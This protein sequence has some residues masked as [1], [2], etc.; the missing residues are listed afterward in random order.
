MSIDEAGIAYTIGCLKNMKRAG[1]AKNYREALDMLE[2]RQVGDRGDNINPPNELDRNV[3]RIN[4][5][6]KG[7]TY[8]PEY[9]RSTDNGK[10]WEAVFPAGKPEGRSHSR[11]MG[12]I[13]GSM[14]TEHEARQAEDSPELILDK[15]G[16]ESVQAHRDKHLSLFFAEYA[17]RLSKI[18]RRRIQELKDSPYE[19]G[20]LASRAG[21][22]DP[23]IKG[24]ARAAERLF[25]NFPYGEDL[26]RRE[27]IDLVRRYVIINDDKVH[28][29][30]L[31]NPEAILLKRSL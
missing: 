14:Y 10:T 24:I 30:E 26:N 20:Y 19:S 21:R 13:Y 18:C 12:K 6:N 1:T 27:F 22:E 5:I 29:E 2:A 28:V 3:G 7:N 9:I 25:S 31:K 15:A 4:R 8:T 17:S 23:G 11:N 16:L